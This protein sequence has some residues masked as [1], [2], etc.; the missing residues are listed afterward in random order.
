MISLI[1]FTDISV[2]ELTEAESL[3]LTYE[4]GDRFGIRD[5]RIQPME[6]YDK[7]K[8]ISAF[9]KPSEE[10][11]VKSIWVDENDKEVEHYYLYDILPKDAPDYV[12]VSGDHLVDLLSF[13]E[14]CKHTYSIIRSVKD[15]TSTGS[16]TNLLEAIEDKTKEVKTLLDSTSKIDFNSKCNVHIGGG[17]IVTFNDLCLKEDT[18]T[19]ELM[20]E[21]SNGWRIIAVCIQPDQRRPDYVLGRYNPKLDKDSYVEAKR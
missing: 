4:K 19:D 15:T 7:Y 9:Y 11:D 13:A 18:C 17:L 5:G 12:K 10:E 8:H 6:T 20:V 14:K 21:L 1:R 2:M 16:L 3:G